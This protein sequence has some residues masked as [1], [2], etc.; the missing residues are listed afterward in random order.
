[1]TRDDAIYQELGEILLA[2][3]PKRA[4]VAYLDAWVSR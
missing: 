4:C 1:M 3:V 2:I